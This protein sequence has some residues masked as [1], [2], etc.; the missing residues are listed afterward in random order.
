MTMKRRVLRLILRLMVKLG[1]IR[2]VDGMPVI[3]PRPVP[4]VGRSL[5]AYR[6]WFYL[7]VPILF[8]AIFSVAKFKGTRIEYL[9]TLTSVIAAV[10]GLFIFSFRLERKRGLL[11]PTFGQ[12]VYFLTLNIFI[13]TVFMVKN[14]FDHGGFSA[15][16]LVSIP[17]FLA[18]A[19]IF[20]PLAPIIGVDSTP[21]QTK[22]EPI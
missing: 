19:I 18:L 13:D 12:T 5:W 4:F 14:A 2:M 22:V 20:L 9:V 7:P 1:F 15:K 10:I 17:L 16:S 6:A 8:L 11:F 21:N 3:P